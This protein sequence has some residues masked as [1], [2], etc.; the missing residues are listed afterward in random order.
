M[1]SL[2]D[3]GDIMGIET[4]LWTE[5]I[6]DESKLFKMMFPRTLAIADVAWSKSTID[7]KEFRNRAANSLN[8]LFIYDIE[9][10]GAAPFR[11]R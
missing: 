5:W 4:P 6:K 11:T 1:I 7:Y 3:Y 2:S 9:G 8:A 10:S